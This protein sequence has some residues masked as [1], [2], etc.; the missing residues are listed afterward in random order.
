MGDD[1]CHVGEDDERRLGESVRKGVQLKED[2]SAVGVAEEDCVSDTETCEEGVDGLGVI[3]DRH[4]SNRVSAF[5]EA[6]KGG[7]DNRVFFG[8]LVDDTAVKRAIGCPALK[9]NGEF[10]ALADD[11]IFHCSESGLKFSV[12]V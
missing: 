6:L 3:G 12:H 11:R 9:H 1:T 2:A 7:K 10:V 8:E 5:A 4:R